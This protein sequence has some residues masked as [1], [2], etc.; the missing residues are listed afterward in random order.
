MTRKYTHLQGQYLAFIHYYTK[1][2]RRPP[3][4]TDIQRFFG[5]TPP[6]VHGM[7][8]R[9][10]QAGLIARTPGVARTIHVL[11]PIEDL[12]PLD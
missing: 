4:E 1:I 7:I 10:E 2:N 6:T 5:T 3:A 8:V 11:V 12:P 9:L